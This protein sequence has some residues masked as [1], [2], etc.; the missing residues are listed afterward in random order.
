MLGSV[1]LDTRPLRHGDYRRLWLSSIVTQIGGQFTTVAVPKQLYDLTGSSGYVGLAGIFGL[2]PLLVFGLWGGAIAD[3]VDRR[4]LLL[5]SNAGLAVASALLWFAAATGSRSVWLVL[6]LYAVQQGF[7]AVNSPTRGAAIARLIPAHLLPSAQ[8]LGATVLHFGAIVGPLLAGM[9][10][11]LLGLPVLY[12]VD[13]LGLAAALWAVVRLPPL[14]PNDDAPVRAGVRSVLDGFR[15]LTG[16][17]VLL[18]SFLMDILAMV[19]GMPRALF[20]EMADRTFG[21]GGLTLGWLYAAIPLGSFG[22]ALFSGW[23]RRIPRHGVGLTLAVIAWGMA[24]VGFGLSG[25][26]WLAVVF[27]IL[28]GGADLVS[29]VYRG[30]M[31]QTAAT[32]EMR[33]R[34]QGVYTVVV[35]GGPR[36]ADALHGGFGALLGT[37]G[38]VAGGGLLVI[39]AAAVAATLPAVWR[40]RGP[41]G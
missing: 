17:P 3:T 30:S 26:L 37:R 31:L 28:G 27:L 40:Y 38:A 36:L 41:T 4:R 15:Y 8:A 10:L 22:F 21:A 7:F 25:S 5:V 19:F 34:I 29:M 14:P 32:D 18:V 6:V 35:A 33:G 9:L 39:V 12:L 24:M 20:P 23:L 11:P 1:L 2:V 16:H 13:A